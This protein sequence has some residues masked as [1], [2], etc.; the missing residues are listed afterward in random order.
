MDTVSVID[1]A[2]LRI[3][4]ATSSRRIHR[5]YF[6]F[7][8]IFNRCSPPAQEAQRIDTHGISLA[9]QSPLRR[10]VP[11]LGYAGRAASRAIV[12]PKA[13]SHGVII[14]GDVIAVAG[15]GARVR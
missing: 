13:A 9:G 1:T 4:S 7:Q 2:S 14:V 8:P 3:V 15:G 5:N 6:V 10:R 12:M 11:A